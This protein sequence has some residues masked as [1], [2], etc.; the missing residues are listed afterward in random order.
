M[1]LNF[2]VLKPRRNESTNLRRAVG[3][4][5]LL[6]GNRFVASSTV[7]GFYLEPGK[8]QVLQLEVYY[9]TSS[10]VEHKPGTRCT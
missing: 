3:G 8:R 7:G 4:K 5:L 10:M 9:I 6:H 2:N 1:K